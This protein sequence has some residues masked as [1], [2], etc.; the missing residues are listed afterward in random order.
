MKNFSGYL[1]VFDMDGTLLDSERKISAENK[2]AIREWE[3]MGGEICLA[4]GRSR[5]SLRPYYRELGCRLP[6]IC[7]NGSGIYDFNKEEFLYHVNLPEGS[8]FL[9]ELADERL[10]D[11]GITIYKDGRVYFCK[12]NAVS[13]RNIKNEALPPLTADYRLLDEPWEKILFCQEPEHTP[14]IAELMES[15][16]DK[17][18]FRLLKSAPVYFEVLNPEANKGKALKWFCAHFGFELEKTAA[19][20]D[21]ENDVMMLEEAGFSFTVANCTAAARRAAQRV[22]C[23]NDGNCAR[24]IVDFMKA[25]AR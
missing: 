18:R 21:N 1:I 22:I 23:G 5:E 6:V 19:V 25:L 10:P 17:E 2:A 7:G 12:R 9:A 3:A 24:E 20:G 4:S 13:E 8:R 11:T 16:A 14:K 15:A